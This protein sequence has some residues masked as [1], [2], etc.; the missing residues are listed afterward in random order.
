MEYDSDNSFPFNFKDN[1]IGQ[2]T[3][4]LRARVWYWKLSFSVYTRRLI[5][6]SVWSSRFSAPEF[7]AENFGPEIGPEDLGREFGPEED[8]DLDLAVLVQ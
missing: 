2:K 8:A 6:S 7:G 5:S 3:Q 1:G 4:I